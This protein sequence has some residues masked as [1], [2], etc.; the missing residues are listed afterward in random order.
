[1]N[2]GAIYCGLCWFVKFSNER[3]FSEKSIKLRGVSRFR[4]KLDVFKSTMTDNTLQMAR[5]SNML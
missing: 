2:D 1:M 4:M 5:D 3:S